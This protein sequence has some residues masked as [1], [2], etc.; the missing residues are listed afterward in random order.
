MLADF[1]SNFLKTIDCCFG[2]TVNFFSTLAATVKFVF[3]HTSLIKKA[4]LYAL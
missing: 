4:A 1:L 2:K 3:E